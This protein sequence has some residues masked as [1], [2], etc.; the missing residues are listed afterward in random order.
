MQH[1]GAEITEISF[2]PLPGVVCYPHPMIRRFAVAFAFLALMGAGLPPARA[3]I[4]PLN[5]GTKVEGEPISYN[6]QGV[7]M[8][9]TDGAFAPRMGWTNFT[10]EA[11]KELSKQPKAKPFLEAYLDVEEPEANAKPALEIKPKP[12]DT[13]ERPNPKA[14][15]GAMFSSPISVLL[16]LLLYAGNIYAGFEIAIFRNLHPG[17]VCGVA[18]GAPVIGPIVFLCMPTKIQKSLDEIAA[19]SMA[20][21]A[22]EEHQLSYTH[23]GGH[24]AEDEAALQVLRFVK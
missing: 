18:A 22:P 17:L 21:H 7:V 16:F 8:K 3:A 24:G 19:E 15:L 4:F 20:E 23:P 6:A 2:L 9:T 5:D 14:G 1:S 12:H 10:Q 11:L 13:L